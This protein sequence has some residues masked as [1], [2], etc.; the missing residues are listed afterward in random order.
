MDY[1]WSPPDLRPELLFRVH[2]QASHI[3]QRA[4]VGFAATDEK[5]LYSSTELEAFFQ[6]IVNHRTQAP[7][8]SPYIS[9]FE[10]FTEADMWAIAL[11]NVTGIPALIYAID[12]F[13]PSLQDAFIFKVSHVGNKCQRRLRSGA[14]SE[15]MVCHRLPTAAIIESMTRTSTDVRMGEF[16]L[17][18]IPFNLKLL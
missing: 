14:E 2:S 4:R 6:S 17:K 18:Y 1:P 10:D 8:K 7:K 5:K 13:H 16:Y 9:L 15:W 3:H 11:E 12:V